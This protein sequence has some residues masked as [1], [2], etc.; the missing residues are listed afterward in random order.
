M[1]R[2]PR[3]YYTEADKALMWDRWRKGD[4]YFLVSYFS[5]RWDKRCKL[6]TAIASQ[7]LAAACACPNQPQAGG[8][9]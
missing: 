2:K 5:R 1:P 3:I 4:L 9:V 7:T 6:L 8:L